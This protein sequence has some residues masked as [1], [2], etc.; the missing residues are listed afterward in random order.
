MAAPKACLRPAARGAVFQRVERTLGPL[1][2]QAHLALQARKEAPASAQAQGEPN[3]KARHGGHEGQRGQ[4]GEEAEGL[5]P[6]EGGGEGKGGPKGAPQ[7]LGGV[8][9]EG[10]SEVAAGCDLFWHPRP[11]R[12]RCGRAHLSGS[13]GPR[14]PLALA[15][16]GQGTPP[17]LFITTALHGSSA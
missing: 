7:P 14:Y 11:C 13:G 17:A 1:K 8:E 9:L 16:P 4:E 12:H 2:A 5:K 6:V 3:R 15:L 10:E